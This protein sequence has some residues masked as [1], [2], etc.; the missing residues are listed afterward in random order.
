MICAL[1][2]EKSSY[3][4]RGNVIGPVIMQTHRLSLNIQGEP[5]ED[6]KERY[7]PN[8]GIIRR[9][10]LS[11][12]KI[13]NVYQPNDVYTEIK[14]YWDGLYNNMTVV[15]N[16]PKNVHSNRFRAK[17]FYMNITHSGLSFFSRFLHRLIFYHPVSLQVGHLTTLSPCHF[18]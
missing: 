3:R 6:Q 17:N 9:T 11:N 5:L 4:I 16:K 15:S 10:P 13:W 12:Y 7:S 8:K 14:Y 2:Y 1:L 18:L